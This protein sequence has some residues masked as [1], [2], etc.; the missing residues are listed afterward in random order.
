MNAMLK[1]TAVI[2]LAFA[3]QACGTLQALN[4]LSDATC[5]TEVSKKDSKFSCEFEGKKLLSKSDK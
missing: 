5:T 3:L 2:L 4:V 1:K